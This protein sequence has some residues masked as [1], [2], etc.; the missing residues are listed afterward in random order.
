[1]SPLIIFLSTGLLV[2]WMSRLR[3]LR[4]GSE[5]EINTALDHDL[6]SCRRILLRFR[7]MFMLPTMAG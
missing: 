6:L 3:I 7:S 2:Y 4:R 5:D 1:M